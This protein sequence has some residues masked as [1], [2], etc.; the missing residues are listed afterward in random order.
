MQTRVPLASFPSFNVGLSPSSV[1]FAPGSSVLLAATS[2]E[3]LLCL[4]E[5][6]REGF[7][8]IH[9]GAG[10]ALM[11]VRWQAAELGTE[12]LDV[13]DGFHRVKSIR[14]ATT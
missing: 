13:I 1:V 3:F 9:A 14:I 12:A 10:S 6:F 7:S 4:F 2:H 11:V 5:R 8:E